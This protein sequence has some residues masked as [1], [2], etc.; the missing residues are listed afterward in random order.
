MNE[1]RPA[2]KF[3]P[4]FYIDIYFSLNWFYLLLDAVRRW[5]TN[6]PNALQAL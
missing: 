5:Y 3:W 1:K 2:S 6:L 4:D